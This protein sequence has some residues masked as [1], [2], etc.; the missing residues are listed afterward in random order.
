[1]Q[2][3]KEKLDEE[4]TF[5]PWLLIVILA[6]I[7]GSSF[8]LI[9]KGLESFSPIQVG[10][11]RISFAFL[12]MFPFALK[13]L[14]TIYRKCW[15]KILVIG[16]FSNLIPAIL[17][18]TAETSISSSLAGIL[19]ALTPLMTLIVGIGFFSTKIKGLQFIGLVTGFIG[20]IALSFVTS[21]GSLGKFN[22]FALFVILATIMYGFS[23]NFIK[24]YLT[25]IHPITLTALAMF[26]VGPAALI[27]LF[28][29]DFVLK[30][31]T[32][33]LAW[34]SLAYLFLLGAVGT[35][36]ALV[37]FNRLIQMTTAVFAS[38]VTYLIPIM[39]VV[40]GIVDGENFFFMHLIGMLLIIVGVYLVNRRSN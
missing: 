14:N 37:L 15:K 11:I 21:S 1:M 2:K 25:G 33:N 4:G 6:V 10:T 13:S 23:A 19:N 27:I 24:K 8:I 5:L 28:S 17:F 7:W 31:S 22:Y 34:T 35:A 20:S 16:L 40:W 36:F 9:K 30:L 38:S 12:V 32:N 39:A 26:S 18:A 3:L 29:T